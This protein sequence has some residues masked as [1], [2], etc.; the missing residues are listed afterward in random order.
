[1]SSSGTLRQP[2]GASLGPSSRTLPCVGEDCVERTPCQ[3]VTFSSQLQEG[4]A[5]NECCRQPMLAY[6]AGAQ[7][8]AFTGDPGRDPDWL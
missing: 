4:D 6:A 3:P 5:C 2:P 1:M 8:Q 7:K